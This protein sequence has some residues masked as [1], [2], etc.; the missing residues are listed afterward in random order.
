L[1][2]LSE[3][4]FPA[5]EYWPG[6]LCYADDAVLIAETEDNMQKLLYTSNKKVRKWN[7]KISKLKT[8]SMTI[9]DERPN[10]M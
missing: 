1:T 3:A 9:D 6:V 10:K 4:A 7:M 5:K 2:H 8:K